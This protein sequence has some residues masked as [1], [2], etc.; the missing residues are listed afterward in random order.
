M[1]SFTTAG[2]VIPAALVLGAAP[3][4]QV[5]IE[6]NANVV[7]TSFLQKIAGHH[8]LILRVRFS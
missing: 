1:K 7:N 4:A 3:A 2:T 5:D 8:P 6:V